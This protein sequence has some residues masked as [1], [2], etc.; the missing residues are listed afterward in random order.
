MNQN[1]EYDMT[2]QAEWQKPQ[3][4]LNTNLTQEEI[5]RLCDFFELL[6]KWDREE[7]T[8]KTGQETGRER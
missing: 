7:D 5:D 8:R 3:I 6:D 1:L 2:Y 4:G